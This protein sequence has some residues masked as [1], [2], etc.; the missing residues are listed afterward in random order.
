MF[1][2]SGLIVVVMYNG[3]QLNHAGETGG[4]VGAPN[5]YLGFIVPLYILNYIGSLNHSKE[6]RVNSNGGLGYTTCSLGFLY[7]QLGWL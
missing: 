2:I 1:V 4:H 6:L 3:I 7:L 5:F